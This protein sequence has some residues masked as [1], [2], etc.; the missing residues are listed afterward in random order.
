MARVP[1]GDHRIGGEDVN[2]DP[3]ISLT[4]VPIHVRHNRLIFA[5]T[6]GPETTLLNAQLIQCQHNGV[7][8]VR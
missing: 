2:F 8:T 1:A 5:V 7:G 3:A 4:A 6:G